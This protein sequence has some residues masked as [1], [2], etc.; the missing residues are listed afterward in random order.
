MTKFVIF[1]KKCT[2]FLDWHDKVC[3]LHHPTGTTHH[4]SQVDTPEHSTVSLATCKCS[5]IHLIH[6]EGAPPISCCV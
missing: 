5:R 1:H 3:P 4:M 2:F 6:F